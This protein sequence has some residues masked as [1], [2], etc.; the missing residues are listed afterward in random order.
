MY[1]KFEN[2]IGIF[3]KTKIGMTR[4]GSLYAATVVLL[5]DVEWRVESFSYLFPAVRGEVKHQNGEEGDAHAGDDEVDRVE[6]G[7]APHGH[8]ECDV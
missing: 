6:Q 2:K 5:S 7:L 3:A 4:F 8:V 1:Y